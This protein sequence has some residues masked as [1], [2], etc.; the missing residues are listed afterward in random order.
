MRIVIASREWPNSGPTARHTG[1]GRYCADLLTGLREAGVE[2]HAVGAGAARG[3]LGWLAARHAAERL[4][5]G[6]VVIGDP[7]FHLPA[8]VVPPVSPWA[9]VCYGTDALALREAAAYRGLSPLGAFKRARLQ[10]YYRAAGKRIAISDFARREMGK[11]AAVGEWQV[12]YP[13]VSAAY[14]ARAPVSEPDDA[15]LRVIT[16]GRIS[17]RKNQLGTLEALVVLA[18]EHGVP[19][20]YTIVGNVDD[21]SHLGYAGRLRRFVTDEGLS[22]AV[23][24]AELAG[25]ARTAELVD[26]SHVCVAL[27]R[28]AG[29]SVEGFG[30]TALEAAAR[31]RAV[32]VSAECGMPEAIVEGVTGFAVPPHDSGALARV[33]ARLAADRELRGRLGAAGRARALERFTPRH[34][35]EAL[36][37]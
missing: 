26:A 32:V 18:R 2:A 7:S 20:H 6:L 13:A 12:V 5:P 34:M 29:A 8:A 17:E 1:V 24:F 16:I 3:P 36:I 10:R 28:S 11:T 31:A 30:I 14:T 27:S 22:H 33:L 19:F 25:D 21:P 4:T 15:V 9:P 35:A 37:A 23:N